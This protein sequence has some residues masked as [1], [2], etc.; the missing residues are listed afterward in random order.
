MTNR[1]TD[2]LKAV[3]AALA[4]GVFAIAVAAP[5]TL[6]AG[7]LVEKSAYAKNGAD[8][9]PDAADDDGTPDQGGG[10]DDDAADAGDDDGTPDQGPG[11]N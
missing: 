5:V 10:N 7:M 9:A 3:I 6:D 4:L 8:D 2:L 1:T 11:D